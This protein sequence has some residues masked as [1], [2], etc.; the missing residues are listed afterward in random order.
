MITVIHVMKADTLVY[1]E[2]AFFAPQGNSPQETIP[3]TSASPK[4][5]LLT[6]GPPESPWKI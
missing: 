6:K 4:A 2:G 5:F 3:T 1:T